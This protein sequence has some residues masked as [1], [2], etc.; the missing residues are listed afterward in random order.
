VTPVRSKKCGHKSC[1]D[2]E[3]FY[4]FSEQSQASTCP[5]CFKA[6]TLDDLYVD[7]WMQDILAEVKDDE[8]LDA[9]IVHPDGSWV[10]KPA[11][12]SRKRK[13]PDTASDAMDLA[14][15]N[16]RYSAHPLPA[17]DG[18]SMEGAICLF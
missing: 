17:E 18:T 11:K 13:A 5:I 3:T 10:K 7:K 16:E 1:F 15:A 12:T 8:E 6:L 9:V 4:L 14:A 2:L